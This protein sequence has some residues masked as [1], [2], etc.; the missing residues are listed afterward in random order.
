MDSAGGHEKG[1]GNV[2]GY[3]ESPRQREERDLQIGR[4]KLEGAAVASSRE[5][6]IGGDAPATAPQALPTQAAAARGV[7]SSGARETG[8]KV[9]Y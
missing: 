8:A 7:L 1:R 2:R 9:V 6:I 3:A 4:A 5:S